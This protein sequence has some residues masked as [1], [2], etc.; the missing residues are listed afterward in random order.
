MPVTEEQLAREF[1]EGD[2]LAFATLYNRYK[3]SVYLFCLKMLLDREKARDAVQDTFLRVFEHR[4]QLTDPS[5]FRAWLFAI[6]RNQC[7]SFFR[8]SKFE[9]GEEIDFEAVGAPA[10]DGPDALL[11]QHDETEW[12][13]KL[14]RQ[15]KLEYREVLVLREY[16]NLS[17]KEIAEILGSTE[18]AI[19]SR[20]FKAR[21]R[22]FEMLRP[23]MRER[24]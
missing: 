9:A 15:L 3:R 24:R 11:E 20:I 14:L 16:Q 23:I 21:Q 22:L 4:D 12:L 13:E 7:L 19:K 1:R 17:Y 18:S 2:D 6:A 8:S 5:R 10:E